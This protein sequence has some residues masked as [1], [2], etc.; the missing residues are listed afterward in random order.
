YATIH[1]HAPTHSHPRSLRPT[2]AESVEPVGT[3]ATCETTLACDS[4]DTCRFKF[5]PRRTTSETPTVAETRRV[6]G[7]TGVAWA[8]REKFL[9]YGRTRDS[10]PPASEPNCPSAYRHCLQRSRHVG[11]RRLNASIHLF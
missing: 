1:F 3:T 6:V 7:V 4:C 5:P 9:P 11:Q 2:S 10:K 8:N